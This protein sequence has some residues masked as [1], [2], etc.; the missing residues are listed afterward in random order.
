MKRIRERGEGE[1]ERER[2]RER[3]TEIERE[4]EEGRGWWVTFF[5]GINKLSECS[6]L[7]LKLFL[8]CLTCCRFQPTSFVKADTS[9]VTLKNKKKKP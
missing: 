7:W 9:T 1:G 3:E 6:C 2:E 4:G 5:K 8:T